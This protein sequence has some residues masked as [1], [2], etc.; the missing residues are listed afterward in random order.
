M[1][2]HTMTKMGSPEAEWRSASMG[3]MALC[4]M[5]FGTIR[6]PLWSVGNWDSPPMVSYRC[7]VGN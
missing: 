1:M 4:V 7:C 2:L 6:M 5:T 3:P